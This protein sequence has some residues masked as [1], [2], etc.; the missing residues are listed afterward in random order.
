MQ[1]G[2][3]VFGL[4]VPTNQNAAKTIH[5]TMRTF[6]DPTSRTLGRILFELLGFFTPRPN[7]SREAKFCQK[8]A[9]FL[10]IISF[11]KTHPLGVF[12]RRSWTFDGD[13]FNRFPYQFHIV[14]ICTRDAQPDGY[15]MPFSEQAT[16]DAAFS[17]I[18]RIGTAFFPP[19]TGLWSL[20]HPCSTNPNRCLSVRQS[21]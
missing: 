6:N 13:A 17:A 20:R 3:I 4:L 1:K 11:I 2:D 18:G 14:S 21:V 12:G 7:M 19:P 8:V 5:P 10:K 16:F 15:A 9:N